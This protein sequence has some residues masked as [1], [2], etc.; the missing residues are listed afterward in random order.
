MV[1]KA[2]EM[3]HTFNIDNFVNK[4]YNLNLARNRRLGLQ[5]EVCLRIIWHKYYVLRDFF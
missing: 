3:F 1:Q 2:Q 4:N 5:L